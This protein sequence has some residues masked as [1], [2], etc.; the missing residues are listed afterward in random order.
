MKTAMFLN[1]VIL[2]AA[3][4]LSTDCKLNFQAIARP[5]APLRV[6]SQKENE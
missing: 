6:T 2:S 4:N 3:K 1:D 5:F